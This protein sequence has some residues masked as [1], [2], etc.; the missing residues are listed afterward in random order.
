MMGDDGPQGL[1]GVPGEMGAR[2]FPG[3]RG[4]PGTVLN[5]CSRLF[6]LKKVVIRFQNMAYTDV[7]LANHVTFLRKPVLI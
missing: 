4:F 3:P 5:R 2:G 1:P 6:F 7:L